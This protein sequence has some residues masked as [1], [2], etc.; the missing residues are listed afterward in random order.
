MVDEAAVTAALNGRSY[1]S[2][3]MAFISI[4]PSPE[5][6]A[7]ADPDMPENSMLARMLTWASP[8]VMCPTN[9]LARRKIFWVA[10]V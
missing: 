5:A 1:P 9:T 3:N 10:P 8:P 6:S 7:T 4:I 2:S